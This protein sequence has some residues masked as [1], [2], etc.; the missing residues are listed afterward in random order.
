[1]FPGRRYAPKG[2]L[3]EQAVPLLAHTAERIRGRGF[4]IEH[5]VDVAGIAPQI[6][7]GTSPQDV[8][9]SADRIPD[10]AGEQDPQRRQS[11]E[12]ALAYMGLTPGQAD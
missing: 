6:T 1:M 4:D 3:F 10:P 7:W 5:Q 12:A 9:P 8:I 11:M 2:A